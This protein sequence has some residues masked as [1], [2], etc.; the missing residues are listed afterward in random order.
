MT[1]K[2]NVLKYLF[3]SSHNFSVF[4]LVEN[5]SANNTKDQLVTFCLSSLTNC[6]KWC[7]ASNQFFITSFLLVFSIN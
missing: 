1:N 5:L 3:K 6:K 2:R 7:C 4:I